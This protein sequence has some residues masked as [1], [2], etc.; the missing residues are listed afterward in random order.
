MR[1]ALVFLLLALFKVI[2]IIFACQVSVKMLL[3]FVLY[4][5]YVGV[6]P[7]TNKKQ[8]I[9]RIHLSIICLQNY[10]SDILHLILFLLSLNYSMGP[11][12]LVVKVSD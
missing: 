3:H 4:N 12:V 1:Y 7:S 9:R 5:K 11:M 10:M 8:Q 6:E 2:C